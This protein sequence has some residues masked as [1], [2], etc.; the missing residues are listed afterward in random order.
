M[1]RTAA[2]NGSNPRLD[3]CAIFDS[4]RPMEPSGRFQMSFATVARPTCYLTTSCRMNAAQ[5]KP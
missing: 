3:R 4:H 1:F 2:T 5:L